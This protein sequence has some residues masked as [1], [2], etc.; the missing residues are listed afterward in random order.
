MK[1]SERAFISEFKKLLE[2]HDVIIRSLPEFENELFGE[3]HVGDKHELHHKEWTIDLVDLHYLV[4]L[5]K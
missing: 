2:K 4:K 1:Q 3:I 5:I